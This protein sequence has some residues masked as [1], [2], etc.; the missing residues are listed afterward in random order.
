MLCLRDCIDMC[1]LTPDEELVV[2]ENLTLAEISSALKGV[3]APDYGEAILS[4]YAVVP[5]L[6]G[7]VAPAFPYFV[8]YQDPPAG[9][10]EARPR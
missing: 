10:A 1:D 2:R 8:L 6:Q 3:P 4:D 9:T 7:D 5:Y